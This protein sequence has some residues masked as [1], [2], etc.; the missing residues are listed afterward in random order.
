[1]LGTSLGIAAATALLSTILGAMAALALVRGEL[2]SRPAI[3]SFFRIPLQMPAV[4]TGVGF[5]MAFNRIAESSGVDLLGTRTAILI[6]HVFITLPYAVS[7][8]AVV[9]ARINPSIEEAAQSLG[10]SRLS[11]LRRVTLP[12]IKPGLFTGAFYAFIVS[13][14][15]VPVAVFLAGGSGHRTLPVEIFD[16]L[17]FDFDPAVL[18]VSVLVVIVCT[19]LVLAV[20]RFA[21][22]DL[23]LP[24]GRN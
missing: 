23:V 4:V 13:F 6:A 21:G 15:D 1:A 3:E 16:V 9:L 20:Q 19:L 7:S 24:S 18:V 11:I 14:G 17:Q 8:V 10:G 22:L 5:M 2:R 12:I